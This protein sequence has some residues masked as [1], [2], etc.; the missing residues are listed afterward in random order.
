M[1]LHK[2]LFVI[3]ALLVLLAGSL[4]IAL[5]LNALDQAVGTNIFRPLGGLVGIAFGMLM[6]IPVISLW[7]RWFG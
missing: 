4:L 2:I 5:G 7:D 6:L 3:G 1:I